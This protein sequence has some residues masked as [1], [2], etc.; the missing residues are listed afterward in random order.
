MARKGER[1]LKRERFWRAVLRRQPRSGL[2]VREFCRREQLSE[3]SYYAWRRALAR[4]DREAQS[5]PGQR[6]RASSAAW[7]TMARRS[8]TACRPSFQELAIL[9]GSGR[10]GAG[11]CLEIIL[12]DGCRVRVPEE[13]DRG[14]LADVLSALE[15][16]R[17]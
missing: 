8:P 3:P 6:G 7:L 1:D 16:R 10:N 17:C 12:P 13:V 11:C 5:R 9:E 2:T 4:R 15:G 14:L